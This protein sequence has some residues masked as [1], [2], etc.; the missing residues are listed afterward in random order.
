MTIK[1]QSI[2]IPFDLKNVSEPVLYRELFP[3]TSVP[4]VVFEDRLIQTNIPKDIWITD[5][6]F[7]DGQQSRPP[8]T[9]KHIVDIFDFL[10]RMSGP[11]GVIRQTEFFLYSE[12]DRE[13]LRLCRERGYRYPEITGWIR[14]NKDDFDQCDKEVERGTASSSSARTTTSS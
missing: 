3:Y 2:K 14:A 10:H 6:T 11:N 9:P 5:T 13:A 1:R 4:R 7:R 8:Y 12:K